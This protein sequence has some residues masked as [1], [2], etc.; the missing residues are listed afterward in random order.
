MTSSEYVIKGTP[1]MRQPQL[2]IRAL[3]AAMADC[4]ELRVG[5]FLMNALEWFNQQPGD[6]ARYRYHP[7]LPHLDGRFH[8][9][10][11]YVEDIELANIIEMYV[12]S[13]NCPH[14]GGKGGKHYL[15]CRVW[16]CSEC[17]GRFDK[18]FDKCSRK[19]E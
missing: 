17:G 9:D 11:F 2:V 19:K 6:H 14:C 8:P 16:D 5:Q 3:E 18:H 12:L 13:L 4:T 7:L 10:F 15:D 1:P